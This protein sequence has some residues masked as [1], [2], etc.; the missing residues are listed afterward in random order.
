MKTVEKGKITVKMWQA[1]MASQSYATNI[2]TDKPP[3]VASFVIILKH[4]SNL[5]S[6]SLIIIVRLIN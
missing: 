4:T 2:K 3:P 1:Q 6:A 5:P